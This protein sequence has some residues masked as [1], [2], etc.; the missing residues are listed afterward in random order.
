MVVW[1]RLLAEGSVADG[2]VDGL[3]GASNVYIQE[4]VKV[5][6]DCRIMG[7]HDRRHRRRVVPDRLLLADEARRH[8]AASL[9]HRVLNNVPVPVQL[10]HF[11][12]YRSRICQSI[13][14]I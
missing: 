12:Y 9:Y 13:V 6:G 7:A 14:K 4:P 1:S 5:E 2:D 8:R 10:H 11:V 3:I